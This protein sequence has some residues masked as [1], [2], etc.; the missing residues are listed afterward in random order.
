MSQREQTERAGTALKLLLG[1]LNRALF[2]FLLVPH[3]ERK[4][5]LDSEIMKK[6]PKQ[7]RIKG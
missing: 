4:K 3:S 5:D 1:A 6:K 7:K 2:F